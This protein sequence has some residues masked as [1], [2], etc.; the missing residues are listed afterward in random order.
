MT[1]SSA[2]T[3][4][5]HIWTGVETVFN[6]GIEIRDPDQL[7]LTLVAGSVSYALTRGVHY[8]VPG[9]GPRVASIVP[10]AFPV[11][12][13]SLQVVRDTSLLQG[14]T[15]PGDDNYD[16]ANHELAHDLA[17]MRLAEL[18]RDTT[19]LLS[20]LDLV[21]GVGEAADRAEAAADRAEEIEAGM[22]PDGSVSTPELADG[23]VTTAKLGAEA[24]TI[25]KMAPSAIGLGANKLLQCDPDGKIPIGADASLMIGVATALAHA[26]R[27]LNIVAGDL[28]YGVSAGVLSRLAKGVDNQILQL[29]AGLPVWADANG[30]SPSVAMTSGTA[31]DFT[32]IPATARRVVL[33][34]DRVSFNAATSLL[35]QY[36]TGASTIV[37]TAYVGGGGA[38]SSSGYPA[39][40]TAGIPVR[41]EAANS[42]TSGTIVF[43]R[44]DDG[45][46]TAM[47]IG[48]G[49]SGFVVASGIRTLAAPLTG[50]RVTTISGA[51]FNGGNT[52]LKWS[53]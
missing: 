51:V 49:G 12:A 33:M 35:L 9:S 13:G 4:S 45:A 25:S 38:V 17:A 11:P 18:R 48:T 31:V 41:V 20:L 36:I 1:V 50:L 32:G 21:E 47:G 15:F 3:T 39:T 19:A 53:V 28:L 8:T 34:L 40:S 22:I 46:W 10:T 30:S 27:G 6:T 44:L 37:S 52:K 29:V 24:V 16:P 42:P 43:D 14:L 5:T 23:A 2:A 7:R 26:T